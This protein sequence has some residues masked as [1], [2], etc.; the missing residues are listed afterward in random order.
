MET[1]ECPNTT[2]C[3]MFPHLYDPAFRCTQLFY[4]RVY[5][6]RCERLRRERAGEP[7]ALDLLPDGAS[8]GPGVLLPSPWVRSGS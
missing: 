5:S 7:V 1:M 6:E 2:S 8:M 3:T 4:C